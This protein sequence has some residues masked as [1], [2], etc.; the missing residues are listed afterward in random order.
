M[1][2]TLEV[3]RAEL[4]ILR[5]ELRRTGGVRSRAATLSA[6]TPDNLAA[7]EIARHLGAIARELGELAV[8]RRTLERAQKIGQNEERSAAS[9]RKPRANERSCVASRGDIATR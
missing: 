6:Q 7:G 1:R 2:I 8:G 9:W 3:N 5:G 4:E